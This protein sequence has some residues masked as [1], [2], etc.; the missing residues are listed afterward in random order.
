PSRRHGHRR[1]P[2]YIETRLRFGR[3]TAKALLGCRSLTESLHHVSRPRNQTA[4]GSAIDSSHRLCGSATSR[5]GNG[6]TRKSADFP[7]TRLPQSSPQPRASA[8][9]TVASR[10]SKSQ[11]R[12]GRSA[13]RKRSSF[14]MLRSGLD[15]RLSVPSATR[16][17]RSIHSRNG[18][19][20]GAEGAGGGG[21]ETTGGDRGGGAGAAPER[22]GRAKGAAAALL[23]PRD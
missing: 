3:T 20:G 6:T 11:S 19:G 15:A 7:A 4:T 17:P 13:C 1:L 23:P 18:C 22:A 10:R 21:E 9:F 5:S 16:T 14:N 12:S 2:A 8:P